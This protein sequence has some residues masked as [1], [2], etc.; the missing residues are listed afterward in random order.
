MEHKNNINISN[1]GNINKKEIKKNKKTFGITDLPKNVVPIDSEF[2]IDILKD[3]EEEDKEHMVLVLEYCCYN[4]AKKS[5]D[6]KIMIYVSREDGDIT[7][8]LFLMFPSNIRI[9]SSHFDDLKDI[10]EHKIEEPI[11][12]TFNEKEKIFTY[13]ITINSSLNPYYTEWITFTQTRF[14][15]KRSIRYE[16]DKNIDD[17]RGSTKRPRK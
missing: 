14:K 6:V 8:Q 17:Q 12:I 2:D 3:V 5:D 16:S 10:K 1:N 9:L 11:E 15:R 7:Y 13:R 4:I